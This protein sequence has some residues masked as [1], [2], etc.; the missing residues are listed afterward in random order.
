MDAVRIFGFAT[1]GKGGNEE[2]RL[3]SLLERFDADIVP[4]DRQTKFR[5]FTQ[6]L[7]VLRAG[8]Y[9][10]AVM[11]GS[12]VA[13]GFALILGK[14]L[15]G[16]RYVISSGD[17]IGPYLTA[18][19]PSFAPVF[20]GYEHLL[21][22]L[23]DGFIGWTP[24]L[25]GRALTMGARRAMT[26]PGWAPFPI[27]DEQKAEHRARIRTRLG[28]PHSAVVVGIA[29]ALIWNARLKY[30]YGFELV[31]AF[32]Q[33]KRLDAYALIVGDGS[34][35]PFLKEAAGQENGNRVFFPGKVP[36]EEVPAYFSAMDVASLPQSVDKVGSFRYTTKLSEYLAA[37]L[38]VVTGQIP[39]AYDL[40]SGWLWR[41]PGNAPWDAVYLKA[42][43]ELITALKRSE[44]SECSCAALRAA[45]VFDR[46]Q[47]VARVTAFIGDLLGT[48]AR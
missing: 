16:R 34:G 35:L 45:P 48:G 9:D 28:I 29:G 22:R 21:Y 13:G 42:L 8:Q 46:A 33:I 30:C 11:E 31:Q 10:L 41:I 1:A 15:F 25:V 7:S 44:I 4:F 17:A 27:S 2:G 3:K 20:N 18:R 23:S 24:Y 32:R 43:A 26:A 5:M 38:P 14:L 19:W 39:L 36:Q 6:L 40:D 47:Q 37:G 12:G